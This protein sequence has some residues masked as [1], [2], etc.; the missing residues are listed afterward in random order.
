MTRALRI[1]KMTLAALEATLKLYRDEKQAVRDIPTLRMLTMDFEK[2]CE[3]A[4]LLLK[5]IEEKA[6]SL[7]AVETADLESRPG[8]GSFPE[9]VLPTRCVAVRPFSISAARLEKKMRLSSPPVIAR[10]EED[11]YILDPRT[12]QTGQEQMIATLLEKV[13][14]E[15]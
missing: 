2:T 4:G 1:D 9:L 7:A 10:I 3:K 15:K 5:S 12:I 6:G 11:R 14:L 8:G 13:L